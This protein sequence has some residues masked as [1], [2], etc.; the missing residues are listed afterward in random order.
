MIKILTV[1]GARPQIIKA[2]ALSRAISS[3][4]NS[5][6]KEYILHTGQHYDEN[7]SQVFFDELK[8]PRPDYQLN[9]GSSSHGAQTGSMMQQI[10]D[11]LLELKP[12]V[13]VLYGDTNSTLAGALV[14]AKLGTHVVHI[15]AGLRSFNKDMPEEINRIVCDHCSSMLFSP[16]TSGVTNLEKEGFDL[17]AQA[18]Y[19]KDNP[20]VVH[21]GDVMYDNSLHFSELADMKKS[22]LENVAEDFILATIHR[23]YNTDEPA[24][25]EQ[26]MNSL[27]KVSEDQN[28]DV[29]LPMHPRTKH[30]LK[31]KL[32]AVLE[33]LDSAAR[34]HLIP[35]V[36]F[37]E[38]VLL[39]KETKLVVTDSGGVQK[40]AFFFK[41]PC[42]IVR[43]ETEWVELVEMGCAELCFDVQE[44]LS[45]S[46]DRLLS[47]T[48]LEFTPIFGDGKAAE[49][50]ASEIICHL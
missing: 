37:L 6:L 32:P 18:P 29:V 42:V 31:S 17:N 21:C 22:L 36:S 44:N 38:M 19:S 20:K 46:V 1:I 13:M 28:M 30:L 11:V 41:K 7:L 26:V 16:T 8:I 10:E 12:D 49:F 47:K 33:K 14:A 24:R 9:V 5:Q 43:T 45:A 40:E 2:A 35:P 25:L 23:P 27:L 48:D 50:I 15:E 34:I 39:E 4:Y 3:K